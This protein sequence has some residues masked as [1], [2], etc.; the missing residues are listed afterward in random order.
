MQIVFVNKIMLPLSEKL[1]KLNFYFI[2]KRL[3]SKPNVSLQFNIE[4]EFWESETEEKIS[5]HF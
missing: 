2:F 5:L 3:N 1:Q 4:R